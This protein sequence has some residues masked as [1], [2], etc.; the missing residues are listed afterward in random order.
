M[1]VICVDVF[2]SRS[3]PGR[4]FTGKIFSSTIAP[5]VLGLSVVCLYIECIVAKR[6]VLEQ[7][8]HWRRVWDIDWY[9]NEWHC[10]QVVSRSCQ[11]LR[12]IRR[13][14]SR[15]HNRPTLAL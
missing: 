9:R 14:I 2:D 8:L 5:T 6:C 10:L 7:K 4:F 15:K 11:P 13:W 3:L 12:R 1:Q